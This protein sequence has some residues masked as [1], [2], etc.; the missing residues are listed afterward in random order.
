MVIG[1]DV[2]EIMEGRR[3]SH[4]K[5]SNGLYRMLFNRS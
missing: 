1:R 3:G 2:Q 4:V 5:L